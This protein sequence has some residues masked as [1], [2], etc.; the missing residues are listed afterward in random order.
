M[1]FWQSPWAARV[2]RRGGVNSLPRALMVQEGASSLSKSTGVIRTILP[3]FTYTKIGP[4]LV[5][6]V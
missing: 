5:P 4:P 1:D 6:L 2:V 3:S